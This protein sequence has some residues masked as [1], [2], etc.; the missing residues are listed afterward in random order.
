MQ[1]NQLGD[2]SPLNIHAP[3]WWFRRAKKTSHPALYTG[4]AL[5]HFMTNC[6]TSELQLPKSILSFVLGTSETHVKRGLRDLRKANLIR[7]VECPGKANF[8]AILNQDGQPFNFT[9][10]NENQL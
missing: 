3:L 1:R 4:L 9:R 7:V 8:I 6:K 5:W 2:Y 10:V